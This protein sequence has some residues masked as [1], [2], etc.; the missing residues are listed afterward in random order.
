ML[1]PTHLLRTKIEKEIEYIWD[2]VRKKWYVCTP[3]ERVRQGLVM[4][5]VQQ[6]NIPPACI[7]IEKQITYFERK[8]RFDVVVFDNEGKPYLL[9]ECK[10]PSVP[11]S[12]ETAYQI[13]RYNHV[14]QA[15]YLLLTNGLEIFC[16][17]KNETDDL[18]LVAF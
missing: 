8:K 4:Y 2:G 17:G 11:L 3:E 14:L 5:L 9:C 13:C 18:V 10:A 7:G 12:Q 1:F 15:P 16:F 6:K